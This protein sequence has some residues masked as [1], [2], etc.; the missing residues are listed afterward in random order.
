MERLQILA[1][2]PCIYKHT[3]PN[4]SRK[5]NEVKMSYQH[6]VQLTVGLYNVRKRLIL[7]FHGLGTAPD[8]IREVQ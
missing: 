5:D 8:S 1:I 3:N 2:I 7:F 4:V 6:H